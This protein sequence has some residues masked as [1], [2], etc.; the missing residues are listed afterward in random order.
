MKELPIA[1]TPTA[2]VVL[3]DTAVDSAAPKDLRRAYRALR[4]L[5]MD[6]SDELEALR[7]KISTQTKIALGTL[8]RRGMKTGGDEPY[9]YQLGPDGK[10]LR[11]YLPE[12]RLIEAIVK[13]RGGGASFH[14]IAARLNERGHRNR[15][16]AP[17]HT[18]TITRIFRAAKLR[19]AVPESPRDQG[20]SAALLHR[21]GLSSGQVPPSAE[22][23]SVPPVDGG[24]THEI[25]VCRDDPRSKIAE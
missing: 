2:S 25:S 20:T 5:Y 16:N 24:C 8:K 10:T 22:S 12:Q 7:Q 14:G 21:R 1:A 4:A 15:E 3:D 23:A 11:P 13:L 9:G 19:G 17:F 18:K 6:R